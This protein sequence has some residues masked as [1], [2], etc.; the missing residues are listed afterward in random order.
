MRIESTMTDEAVLREL[1][2]RLERERLSRNLT[3]AA[4]AERAGVSKRTIE[5]F[6]SGEVG[7]QLTGFLRICRAMEVLGALDLILPD[8]MPSPMELL[9]HQGKR[10][11]RA[12]TSREPDQPQKPWTWGEES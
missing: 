8:K 9:K 7:T 6:E 10:R 4:L 5:R 3:Q 1:G 11:R 2:E 12:T